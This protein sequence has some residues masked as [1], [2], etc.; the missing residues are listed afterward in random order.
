M[1]LEC[2]CTADCTHLGS[3]LHT[4]QYQYRSA[5]PP[6]AWSLL[7]SDNAIQ[8]EPR[9][10]QRCCNIYITHSSSG[11][12]SYSHDTLHILL[13]KALVTPEWPLTLYW[14]SSVSAVF[15][16]IF[17]HFKSLT[18]DCVCLKLIKSKLEI[19]GP[20]RSL[21]RAVAALR[22]A[23]VICLCTA[24]LAAASLVQA[25]CAVGNAVTHQDWI[26]ALLAATLE[27]LREA[28]H[29]PTWYA[30]T[31]TIF[32]FNTEFYRYSTT[33]WNKGKLK[34]GTFKLL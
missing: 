2:W 12:Q 25:V 10:N 24:Y 15:L 29:H 11:K 20:H 4:H 7:H 18:T 6:L 17:P 3:G 31:L 13:Q 27:L 14:Y 33:F 21:R 26:Q 28:C 8:P 22:A 19:R 5:R 32:M 30:H 23:A 9:S 1:S 34:V 16:F